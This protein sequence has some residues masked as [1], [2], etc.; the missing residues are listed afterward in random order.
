MKINSSKSSHAKGTVGAMAIIPGL[1]F[2]SVFTIW[3]S[4][5]VISYMVGASWGGYY[6]TLSYCEPR[7]DD[8][9]SSGIRPY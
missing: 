1:R 7:A 5:I 6:D 8:T 4:S 9:N 2:A 3:I